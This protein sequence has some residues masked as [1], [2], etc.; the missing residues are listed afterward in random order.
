M[1][2]VNKKSV[3]KAVSQRTKTN[4]V[5]KRGFWLT[6]WMCLILTVNIVSSL[7][8]L[9][10]AEDIYKLSV[11]LPIGLIYLLGLVCLTNVVFAL[12]LL[13]WKKWAFYGIVI[14]TTFNLIVNIIIG[15]G[16][17]GSLISEFLV[18][19]LYLFMSSKWRFFK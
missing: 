3:K 12:F 16:F 4:D 5:Q 15:Q 19:I 6:F 17:L 10:G 14:L 18:L 1:K 8:Y 9:F 7:F 2:R 11:N 13:T